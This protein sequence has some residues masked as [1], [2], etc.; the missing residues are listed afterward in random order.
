MVAALA[1]GFGYV[2]A[3][4]IWPFTGCRKCDGRG[5]FR[6][7]SGRAWRHCRRCKGSGSRVRTGRR[8]WTWLAAVKKAAID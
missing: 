4:R 3:C 6:S 1:G 5:Q 2:V 8:I 7:P